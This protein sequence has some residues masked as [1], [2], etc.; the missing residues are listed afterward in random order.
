[1][2][3]TRN[4][5]TLLRGQLLKHVGAMLLASIGLSLIASSAALAAD[6]STV[7]LE[8]TCQTALDHGYQGIEAAMCDWWVRPCGVCGVEAKPLDY[9]LPATLKNADL[10][11][12][13]VKELRAGTIQ[14]GRPA[15]QAVEKI[16]RAHYPCAAQDGSRG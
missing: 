1:M 8:R 13:V 6:V 4:P 3:E 9:C 14:A 10:A 16:L 11:A 5:A 7:E 12:V 2:H 15:R